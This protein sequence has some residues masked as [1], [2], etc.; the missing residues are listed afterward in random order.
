[1]PVFNLVNSEN[2]IESQNI[3]KN[4]FN[5]WL[6]SN[7]KIKLKPGTNVLKITY[8]DS[9]KD[10]IVP[11]LKLISKTYQEYAVKNKEEEINYGINFT[12]QQIKLYKKSSKESFINLQKYADKYDLMPINIDQGLPV[13]NVERNQIEIGNKIREINEL[14]KYLGEDNITENSILEYS[15]KFEGS[16]GLIQKIEEIDDK[17]V[18]WA[19]IY[20]DDVIEIKRM[21][22]LKNNLILSLKDKLIRLLESEKNSLIVTRNA[23]DR[24]QE[25]ITNYKLIAL[26]TIQEFDVLKRLETSYK[27]LS[28]E[29]EKSVRPWKLIAE[30][31][32]SPFPTRP[33]K[34]KI[35]FFGTFL[36]VLASIL[37]IN[38]L[39][40]KSG[41]I[42]NINNIEKIIGSKKIITFYRDSLEDQISKIKLLKN[43]LLSEFSD[44]EINIYD[45]TVNCKDKVKD[46]YK[47][48][49]KEFVSVK[50][51]EN[52]NISTKNNCLN[53]LLLKIGETDLGE[54]KKLLEILKLA[55][56]SQIIWIEI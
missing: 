35:V 28:Q 46:I 5:E 32:L 56:D 26:D 14:L 18:E 3:N 9:N 43:G 34:K 8:Q 52:S 27:F 53:I 16:F 39:E 22:K 23:L 25:I 42:Y 7:V 15:R 48:F 38:L 36:S 40:L 37:I 41:K 31:Y 17:L 47:N 55:N 51:L 45:L 44:S 24:P 49:S 12:K 50:L 29:K 10:I 19:N 21:K 54:L 13:L 30:P 6:K 2:K 11:A 4:D 1:M 20:K 33:N